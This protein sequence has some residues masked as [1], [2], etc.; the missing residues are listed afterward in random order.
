[1]LCQCFRPWQPPPFCQ[2]M[3]EL[4]ASGGQDGNIHEQEL[5]HDGPC[6]EAVGSGADQCIRHHSCRTQEADPGLARTQEEAWQTVHQLGTTGT[7]RDNSCTSQPY[8]TLIQLHFFLFTWKCCHIVITW[9]S[10]TFPLT[11]FEW[12]CSLK[13]IFNCFTNY[14]RIHVDALPVTYWDFCIAYKWFDDICEI[15][16][17]CQSIKAFKTEALSSLV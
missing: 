16:P 9:K 8:P 15:F 4:S 11:Y 7:K 5:W 17:F 13:L 6:Y 3:A 1:M 12:I 10:C 2:W 14:I